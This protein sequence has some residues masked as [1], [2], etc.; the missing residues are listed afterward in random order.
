MRP[1]DVELNFIDK[2]CVLISVVVK[3]V[4]FWVFVAF[5]ILSSIYFYFSYNKPGG[6]CGCTREINSTG[7]S[8]GIA[9]FF[10]AITIGL[11]LMI[12]A[13]WIDIG[14]EIFYEIID[15]AKINFSRRFNKE[16]IKYKKKVYDK[17][18]KDLLK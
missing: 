7:E 6:L 10:S 14:R 12:R 3:S 1:E 11:S 15:A 5:S 8:I 4:T 18:D 16:S 9:M 17:V 13:F 2:V